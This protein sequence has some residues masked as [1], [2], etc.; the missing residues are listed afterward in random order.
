MKK[1]TKRL[2]AMVLMLTLLLS[3][4]APLYVKAEESYDIENHAFEDGKSFIRIEDEN[5]V[6]FYGVTGDS[7]VEDTAFTDIDVISSLSEYNE[8]SHIRT[9]TKKDIASVSTTPLPDSIDNSQNEYFPEIGNQG[10]LGSCTAW[11]QVYY[12]FTYMM[13]KELGIATTKDNTFSPQWAYNVVAGTAEMIGP[14][15]SLFAFMKKQ[16]NVFLNQVPYDLNVSSFSPTEEIWKTALKYR[17]KDYQKF[18]AIGT[19]ETQITSPKDSDLVLIKS[20]LHNGEVLTYSTY[21][22]SWQTTKLKTNTGAS[23]N[24]NYAGQYAVTSQIGKDGAH[25]MTLVGY[26]DNLWIDIN[27]NDKV[28]SGETGAFKIANSWGTDYG[29]NGYMWVAYDA[30]NEESCVE[31]V[32]ADPSRE[33]IFSEIVRIEVRPYNTDAQLYLKYTLNTSDRTQTMV[34]LTAEKDGTIYSSEVVSNQYSGDKIAYDGGTKATDATMTMLLSNV[35]KDITPDSFSDYTWSVRFVDLVNDSNLFTVKDAVIVDEINNTTYKPNNIYPFTLD[36]NEKTVLCSESNLN[37]AVIYYRGYETPYINYRI[38]DGNWISSTGTEMTYNIERRG[39]THK[40]V[41]DLKNTDHATVY[42][43]D[44]DKKTDNNSGK[45]F[46]ATRGINYYVTENEAKPINVTLNDSADDTVDINDYNEFTATINGGYAPYLYQFTFI[47]MD[48]GEKT[49]EEYDEKEKQGFYFRAAGNYKVTVDVMDYSDK[50]VS[51][52]MEVKVEDL[53]FKFNTLT[54]SEGTQFVGD[55]VSFNAITKYEKINFRGYSTNEY[56][57]VVKDQNSNI[58]FDETKKSN[59]FNMNYRS[60]EIYQSFIPEKAG[61]YTVT[62]SSTDGNKEYAEKSL[63]F[64]V[65]DKLYGDSDGN[66]S[67]NII[68]STTIQLYLANKIDEPLIRLEMADCDVNNDVNIMDATIIQLYLAHKDNCGQTGK[69][70]QYIPPTELPTQAPTT[71]PTQNPTTNPEGNKV[72]FTNS[73]KWSGT[74]YCYYW[75]D[76]N[77]AMTSW[78]GVKMTNSGTNDF[79][80]TLYTLNVPSGA[81]YLIFTNGSSQTVDIKYNGGVVRYYPLNSKTGNSFNVETW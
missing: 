9:N 79:N 62:V 72:T 80:E 57:F 41:I 25:R 34:Y 15:Y 29:N 81:T 35:I 67:V 12:Q 64:I 6:Q 43:T 38:A 16:G 14:Y 30:L 31:G 73:L 63:S 53:P 56:R 55:S 42:F 44:G 10:S 22:N 47:N 70:I 17:I 45:Y 2:C 36:G 76:Q 26:D 24:S 66:T 19:A 40:Y 18:E 21:V 13:N 48:T 68:D 78:P 3:I 75:S 65:Y 59:K 4:I 61:E 1:R 23:Y 5:S 52:S 49:I 20:A 8:L 54:I 28:D 69:V 71:A 39:Y 7:P 77:T 27:A 46:T 74:I 50:V 58:C 32:V 11:A 60:S 33:A 37:H 51:A